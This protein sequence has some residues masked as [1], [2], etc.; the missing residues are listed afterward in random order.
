M[1]CFILMKLFEDRAIWRGGIGSHDCHNEM[2]FLVLTR[3]CEMDLVSR[4]GRAFLAA[5]PCFDIVGRGDQQG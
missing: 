1:C 2:R 3:L 5:G 4:P